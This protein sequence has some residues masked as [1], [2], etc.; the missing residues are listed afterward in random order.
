MDF[1]TDNLLARSLLTLSTLGYSLILVF[2]D[3]NR[4]HATNPLWTGHARF[5]VVWQVLSNCGV[6][7]IVLG[8]IW[9]AGPIAKLW[10]GAAFAMVMYAAFFAT[11][12][13]MKLFGGALLD[14]NGVPPI[15]TLNVGGKPLQVDA[16][17]T[18]FGAMA[19]I[20]IV[21]ML[22]IR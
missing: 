4:T 2:A 3:F 13:A 6:A 5:H 17:V 20:A 11:A 9:T 8:L 16:N 14:V 12:F 15:T 19:V 22:L 21:A 1:A 10:L 7:L 18:V